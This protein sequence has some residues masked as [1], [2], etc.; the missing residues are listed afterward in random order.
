MPQGRLSKRE[1]TAKEEETLEDRGNGRKTF[2]A[3]TT[4]EV[5]REKKKKNLPITFFSVRIS[6]Y[7]EVRN[8]LKRNLLDTWSVSSIS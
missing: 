2:D 3:R 6:F 4:A 7:T 1:E 5:T 8:S